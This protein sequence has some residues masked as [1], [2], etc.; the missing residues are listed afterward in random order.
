MRYYRELSGQVMGMLAR[1][2]DRVEAAGLDEAY[3]DLSDSAAPR[4]CGRRIKHEVRLE[5]GLV[6]S[7]GLAPNKLLAKIASDLDKPDG[8]RVLRRDQWLDVV[9]G[10]PV[11]LIP[12]VGPK[13]QERLATIGVSTV[14]ELARGQLSTLKRAFGPR[15]AHLLQSRANGIDDSPVVTEREPKSESRETT[16]ATDV[17]DKAV[18]HDTLERLVDDLC[19]NLASSGYRGRTVTLKVRLRPFRTHT[20]SRTIDPATRDPMVVGAIARQLL[21]SLEMRTPVRLIGVGLTSLSPDDLKPDT[22]SDAGSE[23]ELDAST[24]SLDI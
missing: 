8:F 5:T 9:G 4:A 7:V 21:G 14:A 16:F 10:R 3:L 12:G 20:R 6:C 23:R 19:Q 11:S 22:K 1:Y 13:T 2:S 15:H 24:L 17:A 18:L